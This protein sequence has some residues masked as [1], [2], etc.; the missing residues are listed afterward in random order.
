MPQKIINVIIIIKYFVIKYALVKI[1][2]FCTLKMVEN[3]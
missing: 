3:E 1:Y 2:V